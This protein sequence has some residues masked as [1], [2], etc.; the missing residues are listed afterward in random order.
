MLL[1]VYVQPIAVALNK[2]TGDIDWFSMIII[3]GFV[4]LFGIG[5]DF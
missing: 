2:I 1:Y 5:M 4:G 3:K